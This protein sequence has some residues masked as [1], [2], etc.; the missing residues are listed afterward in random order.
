MYDAASFQYAV[1]ADDGRPPV[2]CAFLVRQ[3]SQRQWDDEHDGDD[4]LV[5]RLVVEFRYSPE[6]LRLR[7]EVEAWTMDFHTIEEWAT[8][9][10]G[11]PQFQDVMSH[12]P[13]ETMVFYD[14]E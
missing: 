14:R 11:L 7:A 12:D 10:E 13:L 4:E 5:G 3:L 2:V 1:F 9:V 8:V 6:A